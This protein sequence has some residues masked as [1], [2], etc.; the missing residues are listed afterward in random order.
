LARDPPPDEQALIDS[1]VKKLQKERNS[2]EPD[3]IQFG[4]KSRFANEVQEGD[5]LIQAWRPHGIGSPKAVFASSAV[6]LKQK[7]ERWIRVF[8]GD[9]IRPRTM[10]WARFRTLARDAGYTRRIGKWPVA[11]LDEDISEVIQRKWNAASKQPS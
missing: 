6:L 1:A 8:L 9:P 2:L 3:W 4:H 10:S 11:V 5:Q 7:T